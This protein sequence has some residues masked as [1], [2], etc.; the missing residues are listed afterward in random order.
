MTR[1]SANST[2]TIT[3]E[4]LKQLDAIDTRQPDL[5]ESQNLRG[6]ILMR[7]G[8]YDKAEA[9]LH[10]AQS[11]SIRNFGMRASTWRRFRSCRRTGRKRAT[12]FRHC[13]GNS[14][15]LQGEATQLIQYKILLTYF[16]EGKDNMVDSILAKFELSPETPAVQYA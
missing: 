15:E 16:L 6:V 12:V 8:I 4:A 9:A 10:E 14:A 11:N 13:F 3:R 7:Q 1:R 2:P 5:A